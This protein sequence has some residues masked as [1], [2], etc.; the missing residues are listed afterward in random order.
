LQRQA[1]NRY[2]VAVVRCQRYGQRG[3]EGLRCRLQFFSKGVAD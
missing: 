2:S 3:V 1:I